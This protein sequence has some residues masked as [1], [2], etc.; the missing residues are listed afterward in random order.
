[1][2]PRVLR[3]SRD[4][5]M[6]PGRVLRCDARFDVGRAGI[7]G[8]AGGDHGGTLEILER[9][10]DIGGGRDFGTVGALGGD[11]G[12]ESAVGFLQVGLGNAQDVGFGDGL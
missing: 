6:P 7:E 11:E 8:L 4:I 1:M 12:S 9:R 3:E 2:P 5:F 10:G